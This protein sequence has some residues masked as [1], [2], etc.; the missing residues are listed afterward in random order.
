VTLHQI[1]EFR[2]FGAASLDAAKGQM[3]V[4]S[5]SFSGKAALDEVLVQ[6]GLQPLQLISAFAHAEPNGS[7]RLG[8]GK[9]ARPLALQLKGRIGLADLSDALA[10]PGNILVANVTQELQCDV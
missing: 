6:F 3:G 8:V 10:D 2:D 7:R 1:A 5:P 9:S 4:K